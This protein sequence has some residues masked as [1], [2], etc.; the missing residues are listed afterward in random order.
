MKSI[1]EFTKKGGKV[2]A[3]GGFGCVFSPALKCKGTRTRSKNKIT[4]LLTKKYALAEYNEI[5]IIR[6]KLNKIPNYLNYFLLNNF[7]ICKPEKLTKSDIVSFKKKCA[8]LPKDKITQQNINDSLHKVLALNMP[9]GGLPVDEFLLKNKSYKNIINLNNS[10]IELL[11]N[12][13]IHMNKN[14]IYHSDIKDSNILVDISSGSIQTRIID[15][16][17]STEYISNIDSP[18]PKSWKNRPLQFNTPFSVIIFTDLFLNKYTTYLKEG[19]KLDHINLKPFILNY[20]FLWIK[21]RGPGHYLYINNIMNMLFSNEL[22]DVDKLNKLIKPTIIEN[23]FTLVYITNYIIKILQHFT[24]FKKDGTLNL[25]IYLDSVFIKIID[26]W[27]FIISYLPIL[28]ILFENYK[29]LD[30]NELMLFNKIKNIFIKYLY[31][32]RIIPIDETEL[33]KELKNLNNLFN[34]ID[35]KY[36]LKITPS[37]KKSIKSKGV[38]G[39]TYLLTSKEKTHTKTFK[40]SLLN[41]KTSSNK[42]KTFKQKLLKI[43]F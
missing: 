10:L 16:G 31:S 25:R 1:S 33:S 4:K 14:N 35:T 6:Q 12:G 29:K 17:L 15:W 28:T 39:Q 24:K 13:I 23:E 7:N 32:P 20:I 40:S 34:L 37:V 2:I 18:F 41:T 11:N 3:S 22:N 9:N 43:F 27:G 21:E 5:K 42:S 38:T 30:E 26:I 36:S 8:A 19:G